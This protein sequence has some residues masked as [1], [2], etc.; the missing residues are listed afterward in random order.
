M[1]FLK[2]TNIDQS[3]SWKIKKGRHCNE[4]S[5]CMRFSASRNNG[6]TVSFLF[7]LFSFQT[8]MASAITRNYK[9]HLLGVDAQRMINKHGHLSSSREGTTILFA[10][11]TIT[12]A[13]A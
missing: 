5:F 11:I 7:S 1:L 3:V 6:R 8:Q 4:D 9:Y 2:F 12:L 13:E 10:F